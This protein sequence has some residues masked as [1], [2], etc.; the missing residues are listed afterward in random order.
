MFLDIYITLAKCINVTALG[1]ERIAL[2]E[3]TQIHLCQLTDTL[4]YAK[5]VKKSNTL[6]ALK[7]IC[8]AI[9]Q[10]TTS[11]VGRRRHL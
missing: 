5:R 7:A 11:K 1:F 10:K 8:H 6:D 9:L 4:K 2:K 3:R